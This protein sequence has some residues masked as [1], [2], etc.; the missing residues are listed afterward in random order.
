[1]W[2]SGQLLGQPS[3]EDRLIPLINGAGYKPPDTV[4]GEDGLIQSN[5]MASA[6]KARKAAGEEATR[7]AQSDETDT[8]VDGL[9]RQK[10][11]KDA[12]E[13]QAWAERSAQSAANFEADMQVRGAQRS[14]PRRAGT[15]RIGRAARSRPGV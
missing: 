10:A 14:A 11:R 9:S 4:I 12:A 13:D 15:Q 2:P 3:E 8:L 7:Q 5:P 6:F 1:M